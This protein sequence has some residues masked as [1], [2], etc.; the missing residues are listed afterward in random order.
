MWL[1]NGLL[2]V[3]VFATRTPTPR[4]RCAAPALSPVVIACSSLAG[5]WWAHKGVV[6]SDLLL[7]QFLAIRALDGCFCLVERGILDKSVALFT[8][9]MALPEKAKTSQA[10]TL[11]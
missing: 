6:D 1:R 8:L 5:W 10:R 11:T 4:S 9:A 2:V 3:H 7:E